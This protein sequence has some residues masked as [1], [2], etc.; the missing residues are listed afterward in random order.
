MKIE[1]KIRMALVY[2]GVSLSDLARAIG[3]SP[4]NLSQRLKNDKLS[5]EEINKIAQVLGCTY[6]FYF[7]FPDGTKI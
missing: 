2:K 3:T 7:E 6:T 5:T 1:K 4:Q